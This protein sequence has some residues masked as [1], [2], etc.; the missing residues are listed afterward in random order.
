MECRGKAKRDTA[1][2]LADR[3]R[4]PKRRR[5]CA[6]PDALDRG[7]CKKFPLRISV[8]FSFMACADHFP[9]QNFTFPISVIREIRGLNLWLLSGRA[10][11]S[12]ILPTFHSLYRAPDRQCDA[13]S[14]H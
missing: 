8:S 11:T 13:S 2:E 5:R 6:L 10:S 1:L 4:E 14:F 12:S 7:L 9:I 3:R